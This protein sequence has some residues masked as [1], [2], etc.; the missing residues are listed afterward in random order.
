MLFR[1]RAGRRKW[2]SGCR[3][4]AVGA[5]TATPVGTRG[6]RSLSAEGALFPFHGHCSPRRPLSLSHGDALCLTLPLSCVV[7]KVRLSEAPAPPALVSAPPELSGETAGGLP[8]GPRLLGPLQNSL[9]IVRILATVSASQFTST[10][11][12]T[13]GPLKAQLWS[14]E[15]GRQ[16]SSESPG[17]GGLLGLSRHGRGRAPPP[18]LPDAGCG[19]S[20]R[21]CPESPGSSESSV[22]RRTERWFALLLGAVADE[23]KRFPKR[24]RCHGPS[25]P[26]LS[27]RGQERGL[28]VCVHLCGLKR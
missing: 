17:H 11:F 15:R 1:R 10:S 13:S 14:R 22:Q 8:L 3:V 26:Q 28:G 9:A 6:P 16:F 19:G 18:L 12:I 23:K 20:K 27:L 7:A 25:R 4:T 5:E 2:P 21:G 24:S